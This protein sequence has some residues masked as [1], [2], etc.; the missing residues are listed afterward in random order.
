M[1]PDYINDCE[2]IAPRLNDLGGSP[3]L[4]ALK[5]DYVYYDDNDLG[6][7]HLEGPYLLVKKPCADCKELGTNIKPSFWID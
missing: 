5:N 1:I 6:L 7:D 2:F 4:A 3:L